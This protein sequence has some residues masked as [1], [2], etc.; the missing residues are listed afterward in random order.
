MGMLDIFGKKI[1]MNRKFILILIGFIPSFLLSQ[2]LLPVKVNE[3]FNYINCK[4]ETIIKEKFENALFFSNNLAA[5]KIENKWGFINKRGRFVIE[6]RFDSVCSFKFNRALVKIDSNYGFI[7]TSGNVV[8]RIIY[9][10]AFSFSNYLTI[11]QKRN[12][13][14]IFIDTSGRRKH[15][16]N[17][18]IKNKVFNSEENTLN[19]KLYPS[20]LINYNHLYPID[21]NCVRFVSTNKEVI[22]TNDTILSFKDSIGIYKSNGKFGLVNFKFERLTDPKF[23]QVSDI[24]NNSVWLIDSNTISYYEYSNNLLYSKSYLLNICPGFI[25][26]SKGLCK[27][28]YSDFD[29]LMI[30]DNKGSALCFDL[31]K[32]EKN[33]IINGFDRYK[34]TKCQNKYVIINRESSDS[35]LINIK[36]EVIWASDNNYKNIGKFKTLK[37]K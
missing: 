18:K 4:G 23:N 33:K 37:F 19:S 34:T 20:I 22:K 24:H 8:I 2:S 11:V 28:Y 7:D 1:V 31:T 36:G 15:Y 30:V 13:K 35:K 25:Q 5:V 17:R 9:K 16:L 26:Q 32:F 3:H 6:P 14:W 29:S 10:N 12:N 27:L 21:Y